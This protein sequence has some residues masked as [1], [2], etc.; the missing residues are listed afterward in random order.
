MADSS[1]GDPD[2]DAVIASG[3]TTPSFQ[4]VPQTTGDADLDTVLNQHVAPRET[5]PN[6]QPATGNPDIDNAIR[7]AYKPTNL[8]TSPVGKAI[9]KGVATAINSPDIAGQKLADTYLDPQTSTRV[10]SGPEGIPRYQVGGG[11]GG[12]S[13]AIATG[14]RILPRVASMFTGGGEMGAEADIPS[15]PPSPAP[16]GSV[17]D[18]IL[19][20][21]RAAGYVVPPATTNPSILNRAVEGFA[22]KANVAQA[23]SIKNQAITDGLARKALGLP[24]DAHLTPETLAQVRAPAGAVYEQ[25]K[26][27]GPITVD[28]QYH[29]DLDALT[30]TSSRIQKDLPQY[31]SGAQS[32]IKALTDSLKP[33][34][35]A[36]DSETA[37]ELSKD[38]RYNATSNY[39]AAARSGDPSLKSLASAQQKAAAAVE[40]QVQRHLA[41]NGQGDLAD[42]WD[43][44]RATIAKTYSVQNALDGAG[45]VD[46]TKLGKQL[47]KGKPLSDEL[48]TAANFA[49]AFPKA[50][51]VLPGKESMPGMSPLDVYG[52]VAASLA[53]GNPAPMLL[54]PGRMAARKLALS[55]FLQKSPD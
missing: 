4:A 9:E 35:G 34:S 21:S 28:P 14:L 20:D 50:A 42:Q 1:T 33:E 30:K 25:V 17:S 32:Q 26:G 43:N 47:L 27:A 24:D 3:Q 31:A 54:G 46:A 39:A 15:A 16:L 18:Q 8:D 37:V 5:L 13:P 52:S 45:H 40:D 6:G 29:A 48:E 55:D 44:A 7:N 2:L 12:T 22:G 38:L 23:A 11:F 19:S 51:R 41:A 10:P 49:N 53:A 36:I